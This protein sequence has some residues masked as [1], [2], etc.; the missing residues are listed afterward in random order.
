LNASR[1]LSPER[2]AQLVTT[3]RH[4]EQHSMAELMHLTRATSNDSESEAL[5]DTAFTL[6]R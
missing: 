1:S 3:I 4:L 5:G 2:A 6:N